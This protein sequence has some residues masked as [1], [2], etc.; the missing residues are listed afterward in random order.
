MNRRLRINLVLI[1]LVLILAA[2]VFAEVRR[3][4]G[5]RAQP[6]TALDTDAITSISVQCA[7]CTDRDFEKISG[8]WWMRKPLQLPADDAAIARL[9]AIARAPVRSVRVASAFDAARVG[10]DPPQA[11]LDFG[12]TH[13]AIGTTDAINGDRYVRVEDHV[14]LVP[15]DFSPFLYETAESE[16]DRHLLPRGAQLLELR[17]DGRPHPELEQA[18]RRTEAGQIIRPDPGADF[19]GT[20]VQAELHLRDGS[21]LDYGL[22]RR[23]RD[24]VALRERP[25]LAYELSGAQAQALLGSARPR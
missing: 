24:Y 7:R 1:G 2:A 5:L 21:T 10:L 17:L 11:T 9:L 22:Y 12:T 23:G 16:L 14:A 19:A 25:R 6:L 18:W 4:Q 8:D 20:P 15:D 13:L 3:E